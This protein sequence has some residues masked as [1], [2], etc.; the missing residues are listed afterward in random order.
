MTEIERRISTLKRRLTKTPTDGMGQYEL[1]L[2]YA[3][4]DQ[5]HRA[6]LHLNRS[7]QLL[8]AFADAPFAIGVLNAYSDPSAAIAAFEKAKAI[9]PAMPGVSKNLGALYHR[10]GDYDAALRNFADARALNPND[11]MVA[12]YTGFVFEARG[13]LERAIEIYQEILRID[14]NYTQALASV[15]AVLVKSPRALQPPA[16]ILKYLARA[17]EIE[18]KNSD[19]LGQYATAARILGQK[20]LLH[21]ALE[22]MSLAPS[23]PAS[24][25][26]WALLGL[27]RPREAFAVEHET[28]NVLPFAEFERLSKSTPIA[29]GLSA[30]GGRVP[31]RSDRPLILVAAS[32]DYVEL[33]A[34]KLITSALAHCPG[35]DVH[36]HVMNSGSRAAQ[37]VLADFPRER[38]TWTTEEIDSP[39][40]A[41]YASRRF[42]LLPE[43]VHGTGR[44]VVSLDIDSIFCGD[45]GPAIT[46]AAPFDALIYERPDEFHVH[47]SLAA[48]FLVIAP[49]E[50]GLAFAS[51]VAAY[52]SA[53]E[54]RGEARWFIDQMAIVAA[55]SWYGEHHEKVNVKCA[56][57]NILSWSSNPSAAG[58]IWTAKGHKKKVLA[59]ASR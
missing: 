19:F 14:P 11:L 9:K 36:V 8:P 35:F 7:A 16:D 5:P 41:I 18:P 39:T 53:F 55:K 38:V 22:R 23:V 48:G 52:I 10:L 21:G 42:L 29:T 45:V 40:P 1:G 47:Q 33:Y 30:C 50:G 28:L 3:E 57:H 15:T 34:P 6:L 27:N 37:S 58:V 17:L 25:K 44:M 26:M 12:L 43:L 56:P 59:A 49:S 31:G 24:I 54:A 32:A 20:E 46:T 13:E 2:A 4:A 51:F